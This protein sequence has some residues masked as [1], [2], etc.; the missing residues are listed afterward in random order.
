MMVD[1]AVR[2]PR[3]QPSRSAAS[4]AP[5]P[6][7]SAHQPGARPV[8]DRGRQA[9]AQPRIDELGQLVDEVIGTARQLADQNKNRLV[10]QVEDKLPPIMIDPMRLRQIL[11]NLLSNAC[12]FTKEA[13]SHCA[14]AR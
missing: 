5:A 1:N 2:P 14:C 8:E 4:T 7:C 12:K 9:R 11:L 13:L 3:R 10:M 6:T